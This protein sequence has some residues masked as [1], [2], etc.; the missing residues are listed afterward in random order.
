MSKN[1]EVK[2]SATN[3]EVGKHNTTI[4]LSE[5]DI[6]LLKKLD[7]EH[8]ETLKRKESADRTTGKAAPSSSL[9]VSLNP[10]AKQKV[11]MFLEVL[12]KYVKYIKKY[13]LL[14]E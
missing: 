11:W 2:T 8:Q 7:M 13:V 9:S 4:R 5:R 12:N 10:K 14:A 3:P 1:K 6:E